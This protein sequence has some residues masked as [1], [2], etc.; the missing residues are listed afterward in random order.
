MIDTNLIYAKTK[1][2]FQTKLDASEVKN[3]SIAFIEDSKEIWTNG[4][5]WPCPYSKE[6]LDNLLAQKITSA[7]LEQLLIEY[8]KSTDLATETKNGLFSSED[9][10]RLNNAKLINEC[11]DLEIAP[12]SSFISNIDIGYYSTNKATPTQNNPIP[13]QNGNIVRYG[14]TIVAYGLNGIYIYNLTDIEGWKKVAMASQLD[15]KQD[16]LEDGA[17]P[18]ISKELTN[19]DLNTLTTPGFYYSKEDNTVANKPDNI[20]AFGAVIYPISDTKYTQI[21]YVNNQQY[22]R[23]YDGTN[24]SSWQRR[25]GTNDSA[26]FVRKQQ[27][28]IYVTST[29]PY[30]KLFS[31]ALPLEKGYIHLFITDANNTASNYIALYRIGWIYGED[32]SLSV[33]CVWARNR[34]MLTAFYAVET[35]N[36][37]YD[38]YYKPENYSSKVGYVILN[39][40]ENVV[41]KYYNTASPEITPTYTSKVGSFVLGNVTASSYMIDS[42]E[43]DDIL[44]ANGTTSKVRE[45]KPLVQTLTEY[46]SNYDLAYDYRSVYTTSNTLQNSLSILVRET[47]LSFE[48]VAGIFIKMDEKIRNLEQQIS[49]LQEQL[50]IKSSTNE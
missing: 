5:Y 47:E 42:K 39:Y 41:D 11:K 49:S 3:T 2:G 25:L 16:T 37:H 38:I 27:G 23:T 34:Y 26:E 12:D 31:I 4:Q 44:I 33:E 8:V 1:S 15:N 40:S 20:T 10:T 32:K 36:N 24:W 46:N 6:E 35:S 13:G 19:E 17:I 29:N 14:N 9:K 21:L 50:I 30:A 43:S 7:Q 22:Q 48:A 45:Q 18:T 28:N